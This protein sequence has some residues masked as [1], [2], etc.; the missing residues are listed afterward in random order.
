M[1][2]Y[3]FLIIIAV[4]AMVVMACGFTVNLPVAE[5]KTGPTVTD[6]INVPHIQGESGSADVTIGFGAGELFISP[7]VE[8]ALIFGTATYNVDDFK[9]QIRIDGNEV[10]IDTGDLEINGIPTFKDDYENKWDLFIGDAPLRLRINAGAYKGRLE[11]GGLSLESLQVGDG[12]ADVSIN[13]SELNKIEMETLRYDTG[14]SSVELIGLANANFDKMTFKGGAGD[15]TLDFSGQLQRDAEV[16]VDSGLSNVSIVV[17]EGIPTRLSVDS[18]LANID[19][20]GKWE[21]SG[22]FYIQSGDGPSLT[23]NVNIGAG[24]LELQN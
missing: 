10:R 23:I 16:T 18:G 5:L 17:P 11:L 7:G 6:E 8:D 9:P 2:K 24:N 15:Y 20:G 4:L 12:A 3:Q 14:A 19:I 13:F 1:Y 21:R 22:G